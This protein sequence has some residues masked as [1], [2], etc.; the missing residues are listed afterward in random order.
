MTRKE[1]SRFKGKRRKIGSGQRWNSRLIG[2]SSLSRLNWQRSRQRRSSSRETS[3]PWCLVLS[4][5]MSA[6]AQTRWPVLRTSGHFMKQ[7][8]QKAPSSQTSSSHLLFKVSALRK[9]SSSAGKIAS[10]FV[11]KKC[12]LGESSKFLTE[13]PPMMSSKVPWQYVTT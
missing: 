5:P 9:S 1:W 13:Y 12:F 7:P 2:R 8:Y 6:S 4:K 10:G 3:R 11:P